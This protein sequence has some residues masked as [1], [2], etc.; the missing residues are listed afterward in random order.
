[1]SYDANDLRQFE[2]TL[3]D[4]RNNIQ[5]DPFLMEYVDPLRRRMREQ[6]LLSLVKPYR[7]VKLDFLAGK[8]QSESE[9]E[10]IV[11]AMILDDRIEG[12]VDMLEKHLVLSGKEEGKKHRELAKWAGA[13]RVGRRAWRTGPSRGCVNLCLWDCRGDTIRVVP[14]SPSPGASDA[15]DVPS[16]ACAPT[17][18]VDR[19][20][21]RGPFAPFRKSALASD[22]ASARGLIQNRLRHR[23]ARKPSRR[24]GWV[25]RGSNFSDFG[26]PPRVKFE[27]STL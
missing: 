25:G 7:R 20:C 16:S 13:L 17:S 22:G 6:V 12:E 9:V 15:R 8:L 21:L 10:Q 3:T 18:R 14:C 4:K 23:S 24:R 2:T 27:R 5:S 1:M 26:P 19:F 11:V